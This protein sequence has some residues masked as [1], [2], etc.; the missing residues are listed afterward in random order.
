MKK[1]LVVAMAALAGC[2]GPRTIAPVTVYDFGLQRLSTVSEA[3]NASGGA[4]LQTN[5]LVTDV[6]APTWLDSTAINYRLAYHDLAQVHSYASNRWVASPATLLSQ[7]VRSRIARVNENGV[8]SINDG[9][10]ADYVLSLELEEFTQVF[11]SPNNS[12]AVVKFRA[13]L[14]E[15]ATR[16]IIA[17]RTFSVE[18]AAPSP[19]ANGAVRALSGASDKLIGQLIDW[20][21]EQLPEEN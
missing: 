12:R 10:G 1:F 6:T 4:R 3:V 20:L 9:A 21:A 2:A 7:R 11:D 13:S 8:V 15:R 14:I 16:S 18:Q 17:Q 5:L 19:D